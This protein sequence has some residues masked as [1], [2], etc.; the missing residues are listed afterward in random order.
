MDDEDPLCNSSGKCEPC[1][2]DHIVSICVYCGSELIEQEYG[3]LNS[4][5]VRTDTA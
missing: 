4:Y 1:K 2:G 3:W 5:N